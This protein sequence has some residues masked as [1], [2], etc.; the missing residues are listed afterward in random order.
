M[1]EFLERS[2]PSISVRGLGTLTHADYHHLTSR[3]NQLIDEEGKVRIHFDL[4]Q[5]KGFEPRAMWDDLQFTL[6]HGRQIDRCAV[7]ADQ[8]WLEWVARLSRPF[9]NVQYFDKSKSREAWDWLQE[10]GT[11]TAP[12]P[13]MAGDLVNLARAHPLAALGLSVC[14][15]F[16]LARA[17]RS[18]TSV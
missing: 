7:V 14:T 15:G 12:V 13:R 11:V 10:P 18:L 17:T 1:I 4:Q 8:V 6:S 2:G 16:L 9:F 5:L 3:I